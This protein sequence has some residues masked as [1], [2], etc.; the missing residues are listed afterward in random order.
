MLLYWVLGDMDV[1]EKMVTSMT[2]VKKALR[3]EVRVE[4]R[5]FM[6]DCG[7]RATSPEQKKD[8]LVSFCWVFRVFV[9][10]FFVLGFSGL[11]AKTPTVKKREKRVLL[12]LCGRETSRLCVCL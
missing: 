4:A 6:S 9:F 11:G 10:G 3:D 7:I 1:V 8:L 12:S 2:K 5:G